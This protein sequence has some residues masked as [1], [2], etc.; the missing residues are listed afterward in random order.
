MMLQTII[1][2]STEKLVA[3][4]GIFAALMAFMAIFVFVSIVIFVYSAFAW[5]TI[6]KKIDYDKPWIAWIPIANIVGILQPGGFHWAWIFLILVPILG[7]IPLFI[8]VIIA[9]WRIFEKRKYPGYLA[10]IPLGSLIPLINWLAT[11]ASLVVVGLVAWK[12][13]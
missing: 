12:D 10:L 7:W 8:L 9:T 3:G 11:P 13:R 2:M 5:M 1:P 4:G 6:L